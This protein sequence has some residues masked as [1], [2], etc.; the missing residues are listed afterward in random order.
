VK[1]RTFHS[2]APGTLAEAVAEGL[3][4]SLD[5]ARAL[6]DRGA[7][8]VQGRRQREPTREIAPATPVL[9]VLEER[10][11]ASIDRPPESPPLRILHEDADLLAVD[12]PAGLPA[13]PTPG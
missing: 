13:Q 1:R 7:V 5:D 3:G 6:V 10:G 8:Y 4:C 12:K 11:R 9:V 2:L